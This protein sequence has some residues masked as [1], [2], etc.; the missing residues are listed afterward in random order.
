[1]AGAFALVM[2]GL[3]VWAVVAA[4]HPL[5]GR[6]VCIM[7]LGNGQTAAYFG[8]TNEL[9]EPVSKPVG[10]DNYFA[11]G[12]ADRRQ[13]TAFPAHVAVGSRDAAF[14]VAFS[15]DEL[16]WV[17]DGRAVIASRES[18]QC[19]MPKPIEQPKDVT[20]VKPK[21]PPEVAKVEPPKP[22]PP[23][24]EPKPEPPK[25]EPKPPAAQPPRVK[26]KNPPPATPPKPQEPVPLALDG[27]TN[28]GSGVVVQGG[29]TTTLGNPE[30]V[31]TKENTQPQEQV[32]GEPGGVPGG[33]PDRKVVRVPPKVKVRPRGEWPADAP[34][35]AGAVLVK[36]SLLVGT[37][38]KVE[39]VKLIKGA[40]AA[41]DRE[42]KAVGL[43]AEFSPA[44]EDGKPVAQWVP[45]VVEFTPDT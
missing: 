18:A 4:W 28:L 34:P 35:R 36:L 40:G 37:D 29:E 33:V 27:L 39:Q 38:G 7:P 41:F 3:L 5:R 15:G 31:A 6:L 9:D 12:P 42:A 25:E 11:P 1:M 24:E 2:G 21:P 16:R 10:E 23:K 30:V 8:Y 22:E 20:W 19:P 32:V 45:W 14:A 13:P 44:T 17:L 26:P 43:R